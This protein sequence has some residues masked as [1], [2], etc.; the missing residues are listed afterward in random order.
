MPD[1][2]VIDPS[3]TEAALRA[4]L[5]GIDQSLS[6]PTRLRE[7][8]VPELRRIIEAGRA[9]AERRLLADRDGHA[10]AGLICAQMDAVIRAIY[11]AVVKRLYRADNPTAAEQIAVVATGGYG[12]GLLAPGSDIDLLFLL[13]YKQTAWSESVVE[14][15][16]YVLW[17]L[18]LKV[19]HATRSVADCLREGRGDMTIRTALLESRF[20]FGD[21]ALFDELETRFDREVVQGTA[22]EFVE[23]KLK[24]RDARVQKSG[25]SRYLVEPNVKDGKGGLR[26]LN[27]LFWIAK[28]TF[29]V[30]RAEDLVEAGL[31]TAEEFRLFERCDEFLWRVRCHMHFVTGRSEERLGFGL[32]PR[33][34]ER[35][36]YGARGGLAAVERFMKAYFL[37]AKDVGDLTAI[38]CAEMEARHAK[39]PPVLDRWLRRFKQHFRAPD[40]EADDFR[41]HTGRLDVRDDAAFERDPV[42]LIRLFWLSDRHDLAIHPDASRLATRSLALLGPMV[43]VDPEANRLFLELLT[44]QNAPETVLRHMNETGVLGRFVPDFGRIVAMMQF[45]MYHHFTVDEHLIRSLGVLA[46]IEAGELEDEH[47]LAHRIVGTIQNRRALYVAMFLHD[48]AKGRKE[49]HSIAGAAVARKLGPRLG[50]DAAET[51]TVAWLVEHHLLMSMTAQSRDL[52]DPK[53]IETFAS[54][55]QSLERLKLLLVITIADIKA[56]GPG[57]WTA[58]K[59]TLL[60]TLYY[61][62][63]MVLSG[64]RSEIPRTDRVRLIQMRLREQLGDWSAEE[65]DAYAARHY[66]HYWLKV[67]AGRQLKNARF[68]RAAAEAGNT[69]AT[70]FET[71]PSRGVTELCVY[72]P[73][74]P[75]LLAILTGACAASGGNIVDAQIFTTA[76]GFVLDTITLSRA[77]ERDEDEMRRTGRIATAIE[78]A[79]KGEIRIAD[80]VADK[81]PVKDR[82]RTFQVAP[83]LSI[84]NALSAR[85]T[86]LEISGLDRP[87]LLFDLTSALGRLNLNITSA[88]VATFGERAVDVFYVTDLTGTKVT[89]PDRQATIRR[90]VMAV[91][92]ADLPRG[93][94]GRRSGTKASLKDEPNRAAPAS[95]EA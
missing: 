10:C 77:F 16:L 40:L 26:D 44:S 66:P 63:E 32:Q 94:R 30:K 33:I 34:A 15:M 21:R 75:R 2:T 46:K 83:D 19:G 82:P 62:T 67:D 61:E 24:E 17:D 53:T 36:D 91:F 35:L 69:V 76:D 90:A 50:L 14:A 1:T 73:D 72:S 13:P 38:V 48:I 60:R 93:D 84:D 87:G 85:E 74:H 11:D 9:E 18:K 81:H 42:N 7:R 92:E 3:D 39:R 86:V 23:A 25:A 45:N 68:I 80:L 5:A 6:D 49:D 31:F 12:R 37:I 51:S 95:G 29:R 55:V 56:V 70:A 79:L 20:L 22:A 28:Y 89:Q 4:M 65:F 41:I 43:R 88:H 57:T 59:A 52:S 47:P 71:D 8:L 58:W 27:T 64:G 54:V 78:R